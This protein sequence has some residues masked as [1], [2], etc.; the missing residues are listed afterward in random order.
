MQTFT[1]YTVSTVR[2]QIASRRP[3][4]VAFVFQ[5]KS[6]VAGEIIGL[7]NSQ[8]GPLLELDTREKFGRDIFAPTDEIW[9]V[10]LAGNPS[11]LVVEEF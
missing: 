2:T 1:E 10:A 8:T 5:N 11:L 7:S 9:A 3:G 6:A 4:R